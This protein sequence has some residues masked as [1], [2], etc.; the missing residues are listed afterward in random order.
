M[1]KNQIMSGGAPFYLPGNEIG[2]L[3]IHGFTG[4]PIEMKRLGVFLNDKGYTVLGIR[5][6]AHG[7]KV[8]DMN[9]A[10]WQDWASSVEDGYFMLQSSCKKIIVAGLSMGGALSLY[11]GTY[12][13]VA[14]IIAMAAPYEMPASNFEKVIMPFMKIISYIIPY[15]KYKTIQGAGWYKPANAAEG[16]HYAGYT[17]LGGSYELDKLLKILRK[18]IIKITAP[19]QLIFSKADQTVPYKDMEAYYQKL[20]TKVKRKTTLKKS[21]HVLPLD[22]ERDLVFAE[23]EDF[24]LSLNL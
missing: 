2:I 11:A 7:T 6:F 15:K 17:P 9:R 20:N 13:D 10:K 22:G 8:S 19:T 3:L 16:V 21:G 14:G 1:K 4:T 5:L 24:L 23:I 18:E 12:L